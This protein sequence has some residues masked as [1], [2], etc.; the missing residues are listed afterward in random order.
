MRNRASIRGVLPELWGLKK[1]SNRT[2]ELTCPPWSK[3][4]PKTQPKGVD[5]EHGGTASSFKF[6][7]ARAPSSKKS[8]DFELDVGD[9]L[10]RAPSSKKSA[11]FEFDFGDS[12]V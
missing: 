3:D 5:V 6:E 8:A 4:A 7:I 1:M 2:K 9:F 11:D 10:L 12:M